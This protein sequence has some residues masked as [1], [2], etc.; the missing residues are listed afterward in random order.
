MWTTLSGASSNRSDPGTWVVKLK[1]QPSRNM[2][3]LTI[4]QFV[5]AYIESIIL[6]VILGALVIGYRILTSR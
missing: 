4:L 6:G 2:V 5:A 1:S 3:E